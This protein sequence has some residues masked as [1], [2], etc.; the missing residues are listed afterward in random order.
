MQKQDKLQEKIKESQGNEAL[1]SKGHVHNYKED[2]NGWVIYK[3]KFKG[4]VKLRAFIRTRAKDLSFLDTYPTILQAREKLIEKYN[5]GGVNL[6]DNFV[7]SEFLKE[8][9]VTFDEMKEL[10]ENA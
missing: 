6:V 9:D 4:K 10:E 3:N 8:V 5:E 7:N 1:K 2:K